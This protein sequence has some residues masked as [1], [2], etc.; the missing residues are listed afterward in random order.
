MRILYVVDYY[1]PQ[2]GYSEY[3]IP[4]ELKKMGH[5][6]W[7]LTSNYYYPFPNYENTSGKILGARK[8]LAGEKTVEG[9]HI[10]KEE[11]KLEIFTR[12]IFT[13]HKNHL[14]KI[15]PEI[16][17]V[18]KSAGF[19]TIRMA[20]L[21]DEF[22]Y[23]LLSYDAHLPS[24]FYAEGSLWMK[25][26]FYFLFR[27]FFAKLLNDK[28]DTFVAVQEE[29]Q[30]IM[31]DFYGQKRSIHIP[32]GTDTDRFYFDALWRQKIRSQLGL[33]EKSFAILYSGKLIPTKGISILFRAFAKLAPKYPDMHLVLV[34][35][36]TNQYLSE[37]FSELPEAFHSRVHLVGFQNTKKLFRYYSAA[38]VGVW[39]LE[40]STSMNDIAACKKPFIAN[41]TI[42]AKI[43]LSNNN[44][45][46]Y[47]QHDSN[48]LAKKIEWL[49]KNP[50]ERTQMGRRGQQLIRQKLNWRSIVK[51]YLS[52]VS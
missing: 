23:K 51:E 1:Q 21:K 18:N 19:N 13:G 31:R 43:R 47:K 36:G 32:L 26:F 49:Y 4:R 10:I 7:I 46:L 11:M 9:I 39:P 45:L 35:S 52:Y 41:H 33:K 29:T 15:R 48:D 12:A 22:G 14:Q 24:G 25:Y 37:C 3:Y 27:L 6:V 20:Q 2:I 5:Q 44:A 17:I 28:V 16:V 30:V 38:E 50:K 34:G 42:G 40:E 8:Q